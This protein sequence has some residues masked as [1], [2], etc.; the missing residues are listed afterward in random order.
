MCGEELKAKDRNLEKGHDFG[1][2]R[3]RSTWGN[4]RA[5]FGEMAEATKNLV[6]TKP[7]EESLTKE[8][9]K[10][11]TKYRLIVSSRRNTLETS[12]KNTLWEQKPENNRSKC[13]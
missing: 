3:K 12:E 2:R 4:R 5:T 8:H 6:L 10:I 9:G 13:E 7:T 11:K 1:Y